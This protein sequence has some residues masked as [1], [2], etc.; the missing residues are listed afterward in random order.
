VK[1]ALVGW[2]AERTRWRLRG[3]YLLLAVTAILVVALAVVAAPAIAD[4]W[5]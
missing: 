3:I 4:D 5:W 1:A 2:G